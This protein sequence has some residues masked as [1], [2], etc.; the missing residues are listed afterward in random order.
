MDRSIITQAPCCH[1]C[2]YQMYANGNF[3]LCCNLDGSY[4]EEDTRKHGDWSEEHRTIHTDICPFFE[5]F[6]DQ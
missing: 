4:V 1:N 6:G 3:M 5:W 2:K